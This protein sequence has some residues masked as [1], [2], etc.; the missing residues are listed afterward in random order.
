MRTVFSI[1]ARSILFASLLFTV[2]YASTLSARTDRTAAQI[3]NSDCAEC[4]GKDGRAH[5]MKSKL[6]VHARDLTDAK[7]QSDVTDERIFNSIARGKGKM[8]A[9]AKKVSDSEI[10]SLVQYVRAFKK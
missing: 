4:H 1:S 2:A 8:P 5:T 6:H 7:W 10:D 9:F 3:Y